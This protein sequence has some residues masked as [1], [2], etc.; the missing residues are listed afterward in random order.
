MKKSKK[1][2][3]PKRPKG[4]YPLPNGNYIVRRGPLTAIHRD[5]PDIEKLA[6][7]FLFLAE[8]LGEIDSQNSD[9]T[10]ERRSQEY[11]WSYEVTSRHGSW[12]QL[13]P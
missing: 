1:P 5:P 6:K 2:S 7:A 3:R 12:K 13:A 11:N 9:D 4:S 8:Q 10:Q